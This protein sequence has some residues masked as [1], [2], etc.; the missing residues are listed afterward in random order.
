MSSSP[1]PDSPR[2]SWTDS[3]R[4]QAELRVT[5]DFRGRAGFRRLLLAEAALSLM[6][7]HTPVGVWHLRSA[8][9]ACEGDAE[10]GVLGIRAIN[11]SIVGGSLLSNVHI[12]QGGKP[13]LTCVGA[14]ERRWTQ[15]AARPTPPAWVGEPVRLPR[16]VEAW[17]E[18]RDKECRDASAQLYTTGGR[19]VLGGFVRHRRPRALG[20][21]DLATLLEPWMAM[22]DASGHRRDIDE[23]VFEMHSPMPPSAADPREYT[24]VLVRRTH[25]EQTAEKLEAHLWTHSGEPLA[26]VYARATLHR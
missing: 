5:E 13:V 25:S 4:S 7:Q 26:T 6:Q 11:R 12:L 14:Y 18:L 17:P 16:S 3:D 1:L 19:H 15:S 23:L 20:P 10:S 21:H 22:P 2:F 9:V 24:Q 8:V